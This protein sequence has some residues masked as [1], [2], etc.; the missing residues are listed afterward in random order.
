MITVQDLHAWVCGLDPF[1]HVGIDEGGLS[2]VEIREYDPRAGAYLEVGGCDEDPAPTG[3]PPPP[4]LDP[5]PVSVEPG[6]AVV[7]VAD[8]LAMVGGSLTRAELPRVRAAIGNSSIGAALGDVVFSVIAARRRELTWRL[9]PV[10]D[11]DL[12]T[13]RL[14]PDPLSSVP[15]EHIGRL[16]AR[17]EDATGLSVMRVCCGDGARL[18]VLDRG[19]GRLFDLGEDFEAWLRGDLPDPGP[20][21]GW[22]GAPTDDFTLDELTPTGPHDYRLPEPA[23]ERN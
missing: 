13:G 18:C 4:G 8:L 5:G 22:I 20:A 15:S 11:P 21:D 2:L 10:T 14:G 6:A 1:G 23:R 9:R 12:F 17:I 16:F 3:P 19:T 7:S